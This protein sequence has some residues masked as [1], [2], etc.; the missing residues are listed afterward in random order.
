MKKKI[1]ATIVLMSIM[2]TACQS[3]SGTGAT[4]Q[5]TEAP[6]TT[7]ATTTTE[8]TTT[9]P[10]AP[11]YPDTF[12]GLIQYMCESDVYGEWVNE[13]ETLCGDE[14]FIEG[15]TV[16]C[17]DSP[18]LQSVLDATYAQ[19][20]GIVHMTRIVSSSPLS[21]TADW[22]GVP[23]TV[24]FYE[25]DPDVIELYEDGDS[26]G[27]EVM[28]TYPVM[29]FE[30]AYERQEAL[31]EDYSYADYRMTFYTFDDEGNVNVDEPTVSWVTFNA[32]NGNYGMSIYVVTSDDYGYREYGY[33]GNSDD[34]IVQDMI[35]TFMAFNV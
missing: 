31:G 20:D 21:Y 11:L 24:E 29:D 22:E 28:M 18:E 7:E 15:F 14:Y 26:Y 4:E 12:E 27:A 19:D 23:V 8:E 6:T 10:P 16:V 9:E 33:S 30:G 32:I 3:S 2:L 5:A 25:I 34:P 17:N 13:V 35:D 1:T